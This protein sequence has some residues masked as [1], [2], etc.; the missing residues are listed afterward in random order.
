M[1]G[2]TERFIE[3]TIPEPNS[4]CWL[5]VCGTNNTGYGAFSLCLPE[6]KTSIAH[7]AAYY[8]FNGPYDKKLKV[9]HKCDTPKCV[10]PSHLFLGTLKDN[11]ADMV[12][13]RVGNY[14]T[15]LEDRTN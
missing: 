12:R 11:A 4:G 7:R 3:K 15:L 8:I 1:N 2:I 5:W 6:F 10:N 14:L 13:K 9:L